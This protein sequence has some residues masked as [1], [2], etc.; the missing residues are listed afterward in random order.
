MT[1]HSTESKNKYILIFRTETEFIKTTFE[2]ILEKLN[3]LMS[4]SL[5]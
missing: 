1:S 5:A 3:I 4:Q 2:D